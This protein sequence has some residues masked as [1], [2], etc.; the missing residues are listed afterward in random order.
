MA[1]RYEK[2]ASFARQVSVAPMSNDPSDMAASL[3]L[4]ASGDETAQENERLVRAI[5][6]GDREAERVFVERFLRPVRAMLLARSRDPD[7][8]SDLVQEAMMEALCSLRRGVLRE[9]AKLTGFVISVARNIVNN[10]FRGAAKRPQSLEL[11]DNLP[12]LAL[13]ADRREERE[14]EDLALKAISSLEPVDREILHLTLVDGL[15]PGAIAKRLHLNPEVVRQRKLR[16]TRKAIDF[17]RKRS[18]TD[19]GPHF[20]SGTGQ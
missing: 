5:V 15:K 9:P 20:I 8:A 7:L 10:H 19:S 1:L 17:V 13:A 16:A 6:A 4:L 14:R 3:P 11:P 12:D 18:Q 2:I